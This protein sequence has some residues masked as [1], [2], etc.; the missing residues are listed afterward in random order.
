MRK[1]FF[2]LMSVM[3][4][5]SCHKC[6]DECDDPTN[7]DCPNYV[8]PCAGSSEVTAIIEIA[9]QAFPHGMNSNLFIPTDIVIDQSNVRF[10]CPVENAEYTWLLGTEVLHTQEFM[11]YFFGYEGQTI[12]VTLIISK[13]PDLTCHPT[14][15]GKDTTTT[16]FYIIERCHPSIEGT[17]RGAWDDTP[18][19]TFEVSIAAAEGWNAPIGY[20][21]GFY[22][23][24]FSKDNPDPVDITGSAHWITNYRAHIANSLAS[25]DSFHGDIYLSAN[26]QNLLAEYDL[27]IGNGQFQHHIFRGYRVI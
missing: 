17:Y 15:D 5:M 14:D 10:R 2:L 21:S 23:S 24:N 6:K 22:I 20:C 13:T 4:V 18:L 9:E 12:T 1:L 7:K 16:S 26:K 27:F 19:D 11:R 8:D 25:I 3:L